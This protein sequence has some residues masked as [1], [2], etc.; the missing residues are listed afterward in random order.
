MLTG[1][2]TIIGLIYKHKF[3]TFDAKSSS[4]KDLLDSIQGSTDKL[5][6]IA[7]L[8][9]DAKKNDTSAVLYEYKV[10]FNRF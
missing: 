1:G 9:H 4:V 2:L 6:E 8:A 10:R 3:S 5:P 7:F